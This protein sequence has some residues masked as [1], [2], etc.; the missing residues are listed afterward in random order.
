MDKIYQELNA[1]FKEKNISENFDEYLG[2]IKSKFDFTNLNNATDQ[3]IDDFLKIKIQD[4]TE[5]SE[6][7]KLL[8]RIKLDTSV[9]KLDTE[10]EESAKESLKENI[11][12][13]L[14]PI[15]EPSDIIIEENDVKVVF[16]FKMAVW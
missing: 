15:G 1:F 16:L 2:E 10:N 13:I 4:G 14:E 8:T 12:R 7:F 11:I 5:Q 3:E 6:W 9:D